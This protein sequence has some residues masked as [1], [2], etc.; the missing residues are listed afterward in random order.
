ME[1]THS[2]KR[3]KL[4]SLDPDI[5]IPPAE[6]NLEHSEHANLHDAP[7]EECKYLHNSASLYDGTDQFRISNS[8][9]SHDTEKDVDASR[10]DNQEHE[11][12]KLNFGHL[13]AELKVWKLNSFTFSFWCFFGKSFL[14]DMLTLFSPG[15]CGE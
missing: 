11:I 10:T 8:S 1:T 12:F 15:V 3:I 7:F 6:P 9:F 14:Q 13:S 2:N 5:N 4:S